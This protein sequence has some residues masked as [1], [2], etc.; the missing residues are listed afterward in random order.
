[1]SRLY[2]FRLSR[3]TSTHHFNVLREAEITGTNATGYSSGQALAA[4]QEV[5]KKTV[6]AGYSYEWAGTAYQ[7]I[8]AG[9]MWVPGSI[10]YTVTLLIGLYR[11]LEPDRRD[12]RASTA[13][14]T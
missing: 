1:M 11:W 2:S 9:I 4:M 10:A 7:Q 3:S 5:A 8:A 13:I 12:T 14:T 6:P